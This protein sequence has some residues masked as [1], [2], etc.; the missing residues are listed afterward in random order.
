MLKH[1]RLPKF[2]PNIINI[3]KYILGQSLCGN[4]RSFAC[5][6]QNFFQGRY[7]SSLSMLVTREVFSFIRYLLYFFFFPH[8]FQLPSVCFWKNTEKASQA[9]K[10]PDIGTKSMQPP[11]N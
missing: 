11:T 2:G 5:N 8:A 9:V 7:N 3:W 4:G 1:M 10:E 6:F